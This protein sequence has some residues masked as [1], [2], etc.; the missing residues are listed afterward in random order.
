MSPNPNDKWVRGLVAQEEPVNHRR[1]VL[2]FGQDLDMGVHRQQH[3]VVPRDP[4]NHP[5]LAPSAVNK[6]AQPWRSHG[7][8]R[9]LGRRSAGALQTLHVVLGGSTSVP[10]VAV[11]ATPLSLQRGLAAIRSSLCCSR[12]EASDW[13]RR[14]D[15]SQ[16]VLGHLPTSVIFATL[17]PASYEPRSCLI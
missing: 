10:I 6:V 5:R 7:I 9:P 16:G 3:L 11:K 17:R 4:H 15:R 1:L 8:G 14:H 13:G 2:G 12:S